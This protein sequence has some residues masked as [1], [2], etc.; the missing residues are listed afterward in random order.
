MK[1]YD[2]EMAQMFMDTRNGQ[3]VKRWI[4]WPGNSENV[5]RTDSGDIVVK[6]EPMMPTTEY[7]FR[8]VARDQANRRALPSDI[9]VVTTGNYVPVWKRVLGSP[10]L[11]WAI[12]ALVLFVVIRFFR[13]RKEEQA[14]KGKVHAGGG[15]VG[16]LRG[17]LEGVRGAI[18]R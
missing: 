12:A 17:M 11:K 9:Y 6:L 18:F 1:G 5:G 13:S 8:I 15:D 2:I 16:G 3:V 4:I 7:E 10:W 14:Q